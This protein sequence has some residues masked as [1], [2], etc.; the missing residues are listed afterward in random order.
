[1]V[2]FWR[3]GEIQGAARAYIDDRRGPLALT[4]VVVTAMSMIF[5][6]A[7]ADLAALVRHHDQGPPPPSPGLGAGAAADRAVALLGALFRSGG[8][9]GGAGL[10]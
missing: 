8:G 9:A 6:V 3:R 10:H 1:M 2:F 7:L 4:A 5:L